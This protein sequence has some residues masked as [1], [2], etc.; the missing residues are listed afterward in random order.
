MQNQRIVHIIEAEIDKH[1]STEE[2]CIVELI[3]AREQLERIVFSRQYNE[4]WRTIR[5]SGMI[6]HDKMEKSY[7]ESAG[8]KED[9]EETANL[10]DELNK[11]FHGDIKYDFNE[12]EMMKELNQMQE[13]LEEPKAQEEEVKT[14]DFSIPARPVR[15]PKT[16]TAS[17]R[18][19]PMLVNM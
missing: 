3:K 15:T 1:S 10:G 8:V 13:E 9:L 18:S 12:E 16:A 19:E 2:R 17:K 11:E 6:D 5:Q 4:S 7:K 14:H